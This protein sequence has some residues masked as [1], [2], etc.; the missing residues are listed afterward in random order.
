MGE[1]GSSMSH[2]SFEDTLKKLG[3]Q[4]TTLKEGQNKDRLSKW[5]NIG[6]KDKELYVLRS[7]TLECRRSW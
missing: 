2:I 1:F 4:V 5:A 7:I 6:E 3:V